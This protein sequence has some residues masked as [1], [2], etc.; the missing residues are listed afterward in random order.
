MKNRKRICK[1]SQRPAALKRGGCL[2]AVFLCFSVFTGC[3][4]ESG[5]TVY[6][7]ST[8]TTEA[9]GAY[10]ST[11][12]AEASGAYSSTEEKPATEAAEPDYAV[13]VCGAV[14][15]PGVCYLKAGSRVADAVEAAGGFSEEA[16]VSSVNLAAR[17]SDGE[18]IYIPSREEV[19]SGK[20][21]GLAEDSGGKGISFGEGGDGTGRVNINTADAKE[22]TTLSGI[23]ESR[24][25]DI[26]SYREKYGAFKN[27]EDLMK[28]PGIKDAT[29]QKIRDSIYVD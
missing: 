27:T 2:L 4:G 13:H 12:T 5:W 14:Q 21:P 26:V 8:E 3:G 28:V 22:L 6:P 19:D 15:R 23:G 16:V 17:L 1:Q 24:A 25:K 9:S 10:S 20:Y 11:E 18:Q 29:Y 7:Y